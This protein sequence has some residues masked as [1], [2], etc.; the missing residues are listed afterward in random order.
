MTTAGL[1]FSRGGRKLLAYFTDCAGVPDAALAAADGV[2]TIVLDALRHQPHNTHMSVGQALEVAENVGAR[3]AYFTHM[4]H[5]LG[6]EETERHLPP[7]VRLA[8]D[9]LRI[10]V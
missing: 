2:D 1:V 8:Y 6:H 9:G 7:H 5:A 3:R 10:V 4:G